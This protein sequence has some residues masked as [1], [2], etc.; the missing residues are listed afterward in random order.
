MKDLQKGLAMNLGSFVHII[1]AGCVDYVFPI[2]KG[3][4]QTRFSY[5]FLRLRNISPTHGIGI[6]PADG[7]VPASDIGLGYFPAEAN[8]AD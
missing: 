3:H 4:H 5:R 7:D 2:E 8:S 1:V 6:F